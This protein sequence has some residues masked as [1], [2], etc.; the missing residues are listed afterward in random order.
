MTR[1]FESVRAND[2]ISLSFAA[3]QIH[4]ILGENGAGKSTLMKILAG[5]VQRDS[6]ECCSAASRC[7]CTALPTRCGPGLGWST[8]THWTSRPSRCEKTSS[9]PCPAPCCQARAAAQQRLA[10]LAERAGFAPPSSLPT[11]RPLSSP[12]LPTWRLEQVTVSEGTLTLRR[13]TLEVQPGTIVGLAGIA[14]S[15]Q[16]MLASGRWLLVLAGAL[17][18]THLVLLIAGASPLAAYRLILFD[19]FSSPVKLADMVM[20]AAP[21]LLCSAGLTLTFAIGL[22]NLG[23]EGQVTIGAVAAMIPLRLVPELPLPRCCGDW[24]VLRGCS[25]GERGG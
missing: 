14:G 16:Q 10:E 9:V 2:A 8:R 6:G 17:A 15:G 23:I 25:G 3:G 12:P 22:Y 11:P 1:T 4:G 13:L 7:R 19:A 24:H 20:L 18:F 5:F 21:L